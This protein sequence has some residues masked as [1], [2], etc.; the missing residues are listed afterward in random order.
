MNRQLSL[1]VVYQSNIF[2]DKISGLLSQNQFR[3]ELVFDFDSI[4]KNTYFCNFLALQMMCV[5]FYLDQISELF[6]RERFENIMHVP[7]TNK[8]YKIN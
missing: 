1:S 6:Y 3:F 7:V 8:I 5:A 2:T 4:F